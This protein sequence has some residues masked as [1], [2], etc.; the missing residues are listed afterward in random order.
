MSFAFKTQKSIIVDNSSF[1]IGTTGFNTT[2][3]P[4]NETK[5][6]ASD[7]AANDEFGSSVAVGSGRI[8]VGAYRDASASGSAYIFDLDGSQ[9]AKITA[10]DGASSDYFGRSVAV[11]SGRIVVG[12]PFDDDNGSASGSA[13]IFDLDGSQLA[14]ITASDGA[15]SDLFGQ[16]VAVGSGRIVVG[17]P[18]DDD[19]G[20]LSGSAYIFDLDGNQL[21]KITASDA[22]AGDVFGELV[23]V[24]SGRIV[25]GAYGDD[26][27]GGSSGSAYIYDLD[28]SNEVKITA[29]DGAGGDRFG[30]SVAVGSGRIVVGAYQD[31]VGSNANQGSAY[32]FDL[33]GNQLS[34]ITASDGAVSDLFGYSVAAGS[35]RIVVGA[36]G[37]DDNG[38]SSG[39]AYIYDLD[40]SN[41]V[42]ITASDGAANDYFGESVAVGSGRIVVGAYSDDDNATGSGSAYIFD[43]DGNQLT[44]ITASD[45]AAF[46]YFG[47]SV[48]V[49]SGRIV[50]GAYQDDDNGSSSGSAYIFDLDGNQLSK[51]TASDGAADDDFGYSVA[52][53]SGRIVVGAYQDDDNGSN[54]GSAYIYE[55]PYQIHYLDQLDKR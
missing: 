39:S 55:T 30:W 11:G 15:V 33:D 20:S 27:N 18:Y 6:T 12:A 26:D 43:L 51:I 9:L 50:V 10:S 42:K 13:Y 29:S 54:S 45:P 3:T 31:D 37:D 8:V 19:D 25:V 16:S 49:G 48:A 36:Y 23:A 1:F 14:K 4:S 47:Y 34:K 17:S 21:T 35:G 38:G 52:V 7:G 41:E 44:K 24:G 28:G 40:G 22:A 46:D 5:I 53:G 32:I 2:T